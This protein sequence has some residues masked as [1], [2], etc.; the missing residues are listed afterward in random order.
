MPGLVIISHQFRFNAS[1]FE[2]VVSFFLPE[3]CINHFY[4]SKIIS[5]H[6]YH[7]SEKKLTHKLLT[8]IFIKCK[9]RAF[10]SRDPF[11]LTTAIPVSVNIFLNSFTH[12]FSV[13]NSFDKCC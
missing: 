9:K 1:T 4:V 2:N 10:F 5:N 11:A 12:G 3:C 7:L 6:K 8:P 13:C